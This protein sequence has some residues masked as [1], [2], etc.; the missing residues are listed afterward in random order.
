MSQNAGRLT[1]LFD[2]AI[3]AN[4]LT[5]QRLLEFCKVAQE[6]GKQLGQAAARPPARIESL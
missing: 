3:F 2:P 1:T 4:I 5:Y 6:L